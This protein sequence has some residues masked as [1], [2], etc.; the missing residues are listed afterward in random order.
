MFLVLW[1][2]LIRL[3]QCSKNC[4]VVVRRGLARDSAVFWLSSCYLSPQ[5]TTSNFLIYILP[6]SDPN[7]ADGG[8]GGGG[9]NR[10]ET[11]RLQMPTASWIRTSRCSAK[12]RS[13]T[14]RASRIWARRYI[15]NGALWILCGTSRGRQTSSCPLKNYKVTFPRHVVCCVALCVWC[16]TVFRSVVTSC[17]WIVAGV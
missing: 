9:N 11:Y 8:T 12:G 6:H 10:D 13:S 4:C 7:R 15:A 16:C 17:V 1:S 2:C 3:L 14:R 5:L